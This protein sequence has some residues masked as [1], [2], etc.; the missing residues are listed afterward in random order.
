MEKIKEKRKK[1]KMRK[2]RKT[3]EALVETNV[4]G[5]GLC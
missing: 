3:I 4:P 5:I 2:K 1:W